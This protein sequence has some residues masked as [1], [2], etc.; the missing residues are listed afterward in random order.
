MI[1]QEQSKELSGQMRE[2]MI[3]WK[4]SGLTAGQ[5][6]S[7]MGITLGK[8]QYWRSKIEREDSAEDTS[9]GG[10]VRLQI[11]EEDLSMVS[12]GDQV[13]PSVEITLSNGTRF[14]FYEAITQD[15][16]KLFL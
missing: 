2:H 16:L 3:L 6:C 9:K 13:A 1:S 8:F 11:K 15:L 4:E 10:F 7:E 14:T 5:Y 12:C